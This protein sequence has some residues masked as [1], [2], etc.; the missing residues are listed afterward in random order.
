MSL[1]G[2]S[3]R[4]IQDMMMMMMMMMMMIQTCSSHPLCDHSCNTE[5]IRLYTGDAANWPRLHTETVDATQQEQG[6]GGGGGGG[7]QGGGGIDAP[8]DVAAPDTLPR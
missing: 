1:H 7:G 5:G 3:R 2:N 4:K 6:R 8:M